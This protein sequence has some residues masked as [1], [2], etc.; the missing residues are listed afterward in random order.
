MT[1][2]GPGTP[3]VVAPAHPPI[4]PSLDYGVNSNKTL[5]DE[6]HEH[7]PAWLIRRY[8]LPAVAVGWD[9]RFF[10]R[11]V[12]DGATPQPDWDWLRSWDEAAA[13]LG[14]SVVWYV[15]P[16]GWTP[17]QSGRMRLRNSPI[18]L[19]F[20]GQSHPSEWVRR[21]QYR[22]VG[23]VEPGIEKT[24]VFALAL[25]SPMILTDAEW[26]KGYPTGTGP[27]EHSWQVD[28]KTYAGGVVPWKQGGYAD[29]PA[30]YARRLADLGPGLR[31]VIIGADAARLGWTAEKIRSA[32]GTT[33]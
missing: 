6:F 17:D 21:H 15:N 4:Y 31:G 12:R 24:D 19:E 25:G 11:S 20:V 16:T 32:P 28:P 13:N 8:I 9:R 1:R 33:P 23:W 30:W 22:G 26:T 18:A 10:V 3:I 14:V 27:W 5:Y 7:G 29:L 2:I